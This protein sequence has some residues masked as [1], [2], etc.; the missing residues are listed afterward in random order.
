M[1]AL[2]GC[3][4]RAT[5]RALERHAFRCH[6]FLGADCGK[7]SVASFDGL[8]ALSAGCCSTW[9]ELRLGGKRGLKGEGG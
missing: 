3:K 7:E 8:L 9:V 1:V 4:G 6:F 5:P 2:H